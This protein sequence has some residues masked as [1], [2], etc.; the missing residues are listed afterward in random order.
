MGENKSRALGKRVQGTPEFAWKQETG[1]NASAIDSGWRSEHV[2][3][4]GRSDFGIK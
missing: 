2:K 3:D 1:L 4:K